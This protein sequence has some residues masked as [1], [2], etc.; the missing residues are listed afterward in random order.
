L[1]SEFFTAASAGLAVLDKK[2]RYV[3]INETLAEIHG[4]SP[5]EHIGKTLREVLPHLA[6]VVEPVLRKVLATGQHVPNFEVSG[7]TASTP[8][9]TRHWIASYFPIFNEARKVEAVGALVV[10]TTELKRTQQALQERE[11]RLRLMVEQMPAI[12][13]TTDTQLRFTSSQG[14]GLAGLNLQNNQLVGRTLFDYLQTR[15]PE[16]PQI[17]AH[18]RALQGEPSTHEAEWRGRTFESYVEPLRDRAGTITGCIGVSV[19][20]TG[21][22]RTDEALRESEGRFRSLFENSP[23]PVIV[24]DE[25][26][27]VQDANPAACRLHRLEREQLIG[28]NVLELIPGHQREAVQ[29]MFR[30]WFTGEVTDF[31][32]W[33][34]TSDGRSVP[35]AITGSRI[36]CEGRPAV[37]LHIRDITERKRAE[38]ALRQLTTQLLRSQEEERRRIS[39]ELHDAT[40]QRLAAIAMNLSKIDKS[41]EALPPA[42]QRA[43]QESHTLVDR[44]SQEI[45]TLSYLLHP[46]LLDDR[47]LAFA[48][49]WYVEGFSQRS[50]IHVDLEL[51]PGLRRLPPDIEL[52]LYR[53]VQEGLTNIHRHAKSL[54]A[55]VR[56]N[57]DQTR[58]TLEVQDAGRGFPAP[59]P[60]G[61]TAQAGVGI[62]GMRERVMQLGGHMD[63]AT[64]AKG[65]TIRVVVTLEG[66]VS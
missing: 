46:P 47:G 42:A 55:T 23:D 27:I 57:V 25:A 50:G 17:A 13:W 45:R 38:E 44:C 58:V 35:V 59:Q 29:R 9:V 4:L 63:I 30:K 21:R 60:G 66:A 41:I 61:Y 18:L 19:D 64:G 26:G 32:G 7:E 24:E 15:D 54:T 11:T 1:R 53:I 14:A 31:D 37:L 8:G 33:T 36:L 10:E 52:A 5:R 3:Q 2:L 12:L 51:P 28:K 43:V 6:P 22:K 16:L 40:G 39:R 65:T 48:L 34:Q 49:R 20:I 56:L 62:T